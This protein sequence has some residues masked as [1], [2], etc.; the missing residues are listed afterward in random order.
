MGPN[1]RPAGRPRT[2]AVR[3]AV[4]GGRTGGT[5]NI[6]QNNKIGQWSKW[7][8]CDRLHFDSPKCVCVF[9]RIPQNIDLTSLCDYFRDTI[10]VHHHRGRAYKK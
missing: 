3:G 6:N 2:A 1:W 7:S 5:P 9:S 8:L 10:F 4:A